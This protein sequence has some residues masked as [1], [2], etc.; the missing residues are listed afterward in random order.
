MAAAAGI[1]ERTDFVIA[2]PGA[3]TFGSVGNLVGEEAQQSSIAL[4]PEQNTV[5]RISVPTGSACLLVILFNR[6]RER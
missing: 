6:L 1:H 2:L 5:R 3:V 4:L